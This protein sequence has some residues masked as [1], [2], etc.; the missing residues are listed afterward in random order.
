[1]IPTP[2]TQDV[3]H[4]NSQKSRYKD[5]AMHG[6]LCTLNISISC[7]LLWFAYLPEHHKK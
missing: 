6:I 2:Q 5:T 7:K 3:G 1:M 4:D